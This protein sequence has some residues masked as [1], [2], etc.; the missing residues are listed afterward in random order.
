MVMIFNQ[1]KYIIKHLPV[2]FAVNKSDIDNLRDLANGMENSI[3]IEHI[4]PVI[5]S[6]CFEEKDEVKK[7]YLKFKLITIVITIVSSI[8]T[9]DNNFAII[10]DYN[11]QG[12]LFNYGIT[13]TKNS[14]NRIDKIIFNKEDV[15]YN[16]IETLINIGF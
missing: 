4:E 5:E 14:S 15:D 8:I 2:N 6:I 7:Q 13:Y 1:L 12:F 10:S 16:F 11:D 9:I 3:F